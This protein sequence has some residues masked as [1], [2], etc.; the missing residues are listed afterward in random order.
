MLADML[1]RLATE[2]VFERGKTFARSPFGDFV[3]RD[4]AIEARKVLSFW[5]FDLKVKGSVGAGNWASVPWL[6]FFDPLI[7]ES[8]T[9]GFYVVFLVNAQTN[10]VTLSLNQGTTE[11]YNEYGQ[12]RG[13]EVLR[14]RAVDIA[15]RIPEYAKVFDTSPIDLGSEDALPKGYEAGHSFGVTYGLQ[16]LKEERIIS[17]LQ[18]ILFA[19]EALVDRGGTVPSDIMQEESGTSD[20]E[21]TRRYVLSRRIERSSKV[22]REVLARRNPV[23]EACG[24]DPVRDY[25]FR[26]ANIKSPLD[27]HHCA[28]LRELAEGETRRYRIPQDF[29]VLCPNCHRMIHKQDDPSNLKTLKSKI[30]FIY[31]RDR[32][33]P[34]P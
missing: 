2:Y 15:D 11:V 26:G 10:C 12:L 34:L 21:E 6:A 9:K 30:R 7:T 14:R 3:R 25:G 29:L 33:F 31:M 20:I 23:C 16:D 13:R 19:Y 1:S 8:A 24:L 22:R 27:V 32:N 4:L 17:D 5:P 18:K 28:P